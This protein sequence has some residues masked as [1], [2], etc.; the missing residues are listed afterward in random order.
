MLRALFGEPKRKDEGK[1][2]LAM[3]EL[4][5]FFA[6]LAGGKLNGRAPGEKLPQYAIWTIGFKDALDELEQSCYCSG[7]YAASVRSAFVEEMDEGER[8]DYRRFVYYYKNGFIRVFSLL[9]KLGYFL[10][11]W[12]GLETERIKERFSFFTVLRRMQ[13]RQAHPELQRQLYALKTQYKM[14]LANLRKQRNM[15]IHY[16][17]AEL[18]DDWKHTSYR[19]GDKLRVENV[20]AQAE[21]LQQACG[22]VIEALTAAFAYVNE[23]AGEAG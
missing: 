18:L 12:L 1:L 3:Q 13:E 14:P 11:E 6:L 7:K 5:R 22:M 21:E 2:L 20:R 17:N 10:N 23:R 16:V 8:D 15:E 9:D 19:P 4:D